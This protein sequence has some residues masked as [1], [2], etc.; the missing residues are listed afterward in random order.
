MIYMHETNEMM[1]YGPWIHHQAMLDNH[2]CYIPYMEVMP[3]YQHRNQDHHHQ[4]AEEENEQAGDEVHD[5]MTPATSGERSSSADLFRLEFAATQ[6]SKLVSNAEGLFTKLMTSNILPHTDQDQIEQWLCMKQ[7]Y[8]E[9]ITS[10]DT[11]SLQGYT[12]NTRRSLERIEEVTETDEKTDESA[13][14]MK[15]KLNSNCTSSSE[16][17]LSEVDEDEDEDEE[18]QSD[19]SS[20]NLDFLEKLDE[21]MNK[22]KIETDRIVDSKKDNFRETNIEIISPMTRSV[23]NN[24]VPV[25][26]PVPIR[27]PNSRRNSMLPGSDMCN[28]VLAFNDSLKP[29]QN[30]ILDNHISEYS[31]PCLLDNRESEIN[32]NDNFVAT[33]NDNS[34]DLLLEALKTADIPEPIKELQALTINNEAKQ[35][36]VKKIQSNLDGAHKRIEELQTTIKIKQRFIA[37]MIKNSDTRTNAK[38]KFQRKR[39]K[40]EEEYY[41]TRTQ[42]AQAENASMYNPDEKTVHK[43][44]IELMKNMAIH[45]E[46][47]LM[48]IDMIKQIAGDSAK[49]VLELEASLHTSKKQM[50]KLKRQLK[51]EE[52]RKKQLE[53][54][55]AKDQV[56]I[57]ELEEKYNVT[58]SK[59]KEMQSESEDERHNAKSKIDCSDKK[60]N[61]L[62]VSARISHLD[63]V[64]KEKSMDLER[65]ADMDEKEALRHEIRNLRHTRDCLVDEKCDLD[66]KFQKERT[67]T[68]VEERKLLECGETIEAIDAMIEHKNEMICGRK[69][70]DENQSQR[71]K[72]ERMLMERLKKLSH[73]EI[74]TLFMKYFRKVID[75][76]ESSKNLEV[77]I[78]ELE[79]HIANQDWRLMEAERRMVIMQRQYEDKLHHVYRHFAEETS[80]SGHERLDKDSELVKYKKE[81]R[82]LKKRLADVEALLKGTTPPRIA[83]PCRI[84]QQG[85]KQIAPNTRSTTKVT[86]QRN[87]LIIQKTTDCDKRKK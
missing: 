49:K 58:A 63:H 53:E 57:R 50:D 34:P 81:N 1:H 13:N 69:D 5:T 2:P 15:L 66:E 6:W 17:E 30:Q 32:I 21:Y 39:S 28:E 36:Q 86:R 71:E 4:L 14:Q 75:L 42:L 26:R 61:L 41:N 33:Q 9:C 83:S 87:K 45:Y 67:L 73:G 77:Q 80:S 46:K 44:E 23:N 3:F 55:L 40:L 7:E 37:D 76:K 82:A 74:I 8:E 62:E 78:T 84:P 60:K 79:T 31:N 64:L 52:E 18:D 72:G 27:N 43:R 19:A 10:D 68:T 38:Q 85:L 24:Y 20:E 48:D 47:R 59:L 22:F 65:T 35:T 25:V 11:T 51:R 29:C 16:S 70:F 12:E 54:E 56:K